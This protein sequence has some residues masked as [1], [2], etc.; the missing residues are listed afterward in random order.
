MKW[1]KSPISTHDVFLE[2][3]MSNISK[4][5]PINISRNYDVIENVLIV[6][7]CSKQE[8]EIYVGLFK[9]LCDV[10]A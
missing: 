2:G 10:F 5:I 7:D 4:T 6:V 9:Y 1:Y 8:I 3:N